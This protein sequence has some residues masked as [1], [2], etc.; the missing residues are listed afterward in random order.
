MN[1][2]YPIYIV[3]KKRSHSRLTVKALESMKVDYKIII[4]E[5]DYSDYSKVIDPK[6]ILIL[7]KEYLD[8]YDTFDSLGSTK[9]KGAGSARNYA[10]DHS[11][12]IGYDYHWVMDDNIDGFYRLNRNE[13]C[14]VS[15]G[16]IFK[17]AEDFILRYENVAISGFNY[18]GFCKSTD[19]LPPYYLNTRIYSC[20][21]I[22]N[23]INY[24]WRGRYNEDTDLCLR[25][26]KDKWCT[27]QFNA[28]LQ[29]KVTTQRMKGGNT[30]EFYRQEGTYNKS[31]M[32]VDMHPDVTKLVWKFNRWHH[33]VNYKD[34]K[35][36]LIFKKDI[37]IPSRINNYG[38]KLKVQ[39]GN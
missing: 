35:H 16:T 10:W 24:R 30:E 1:P 21:F 7:P 11:I 13:K 2:N 26:L 25:V 9:S 38:M 18:H 29:D 37:N 34:F 36:K 31:Q 5:E 32:L 4:E 39:N 20:L 33:N 19:K 17:I 8:N 12:S 22:R 14:E 15:S 28:F 27:I 3:S 6:N 23:D